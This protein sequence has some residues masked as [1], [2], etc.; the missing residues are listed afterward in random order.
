MKKT[1]IKNEKEIQELIAKNPSL[2]GL[3][4]LKL[5]ERERRYPDGTIL[6]L[7]FK[8]VDDVQYLVEIQLGDINADHIT[9][10][11]NYYEMEKEETPNKKI[12]PVI[13]AEDVNKYLKILLK[14]T[15]DIQLVIIKMD[16]EKSKFNIVDI[17]DII[18][19]T[20]YE[21]TDRETFEKNNKYYKMDVF[22]SLCDIFNQIT[23][24]YKLTYG[25]NNTVTLK[26][27]YTSNFISFR[28]SKSSVRTIVKIDKSNYWDSK[29]SA[30]GTGEIKSNNGYTLTISNDTL[31]D[32][33]NV[34]A[35]EE[36][37]RVAYNNVK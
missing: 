6:D 20:N 25:I 24:E 7:L 10:I 23:T 37:F 9:R 21:I 19:N 31:K 33:N 5:Q 1:T 4:E 12:I 15:K 30:F 2:L 14:R 18:K 16:V 28:L 26:G 17:S 29:I 36:L 11:E 3:G 8:G 35:I 32:V 34:K 22:N 13:I 27:K